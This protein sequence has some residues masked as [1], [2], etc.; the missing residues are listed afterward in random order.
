[1]AKRKDNK[2]LPHLHKFTYHVREADGTIT[3]IPAWA[4]VFPADEEVEMLLTESHVQK[5]ILLNGAGNT[6]TCAGAICTIEHRHVFPHHVTGGIDWLYSRAFVV[7]K[8]KN[9]LPSECYVY[10]HHDNVA[11]LFDTKKGQDK[12]LK[13]LQK[14][15][16]RTIRL[17]PARVR[18]TQSGIFKATGRRTGERTA[19]PHSLRRNGAELRAIIAG[20]GGF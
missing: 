6:M 11:R 13:E 19:R 8:Y 3:K 4:K 12:L 5:S 18:P 20:Q 1:M 15:G 9:G 7:S 10:L 17:Y 2:A 14:N 16:P